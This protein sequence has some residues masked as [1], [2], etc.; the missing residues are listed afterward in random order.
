MC[1]V[2]ACV[3]PESRLDEFD[4][5]APDADDVTVTGAC[6]DIDGPFLFSIDLKSILP[7]TLV[8][9]IVVVDV[10]ID[11][12]P[13]MLNRLQLD[14]VDYETLEIIP[15][16]TILWEN[17][18]IDCATGSFELPMVDTVIPARSKVI[19]DT[20]DV[21]AN[22]AMT[23]TISDGDFWCGGVAGETSLG[24]SLDGSTFAASRLGAVGTEPATGI[25]NL[26][27]AESTISEC[28]EDSGGSD[29]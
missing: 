13:A 24:S 8:R 16:T 3:D 21:V 7:G 28:V 2:S 12:E 5:R 23:A 20:L 17:I 19:V 9:G 10:T 18:P 29:S 15:D 11:Q 27:D 22:G 26:P 25:E 1:T 14:P 4:E 6:A